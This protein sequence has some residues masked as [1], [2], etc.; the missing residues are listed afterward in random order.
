M[1]DSKIV[2]S[3]QAV[4]F[5]ELASLPSVITV[6]KQR[7]FGTCSED[8]KRPPW[9]L[10]TPPIPQSAPDLTLVQIPSKIKEY[11]HFLTH[12]YNTG[13]GSGLVAGTGDA[14]TSHPRSSL[15]E[16]Q[17]EDLIKYGARPLLY[18]QPSLRK[19]LG[20]ILSSPLGHLRRGG[21]TSIPP[22]NFQ[23]R[24]IR[25]FCVAGDERRSGRGS[26]LLLGV[27][28]D[29][30]LLDQHYTIF[31]KE[32][33][34]LAGA[35]PSLYSSRWMYRRVSLD[36]SGD[37]RRVSELARLQLQNTI[38]IY[39]LDKPAALYNVPPESHRLAT[40]VFLYEGFRGAVIAAFTPAYQSHPAGGEI[41]FQTGWFEHGNLLPTERS[42]A[43][44]QLSSAAAVAM[45]APWVWMD[46][47]TVAGARRLP[48]VWKADGPFHWYAYNWSAGLYG[49]A[50]LFLLI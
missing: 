40:R 41:I 10:P 5:W 49:T 46:T 42:D 8:M 32:G 16:E 33:L 39:A 50:N 12:H 27:L 38:A 19:L 3:T 4:H 17:L 18:Y 24:L 14:V 25:D 13:S 9:V 34:P 21:S 11:C 22:T 31:L 23:L 20:A 45:N 30:A 37:N 43:A 47:A 44:Q 1:N 26:E 2:P 7:F 15:T 28:R 48:A 35:G 29:C 6:L 36:A